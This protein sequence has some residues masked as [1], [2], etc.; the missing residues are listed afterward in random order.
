MLLAFGF[1]F[2]MQRD[3]AT[4]VG[5]EFGPMAHGGTADG[6]DIEADGKRKA[7][8]ENSGARNINERIEGEDRAVFTERKSLLSFN[9]NVRFDGRGFKGEFGAGIGIT[10]SAARGVGLSAATLAPF[11]FGR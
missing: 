2:E 11:S 4:S 3:E 5:L 8:A 10:E 7:E 9:A 6:F 1:A